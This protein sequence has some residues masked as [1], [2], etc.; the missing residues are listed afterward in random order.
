MIVIVVIVLGVVVYIGF[1]LY[2]KIFDHHT[3]KINK[4]DEKTKTLEEELKTLR[5]Q[6]RLKEEINERQAPIIIE[7]QNMELAEAIIEK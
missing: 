5:E 4:L 7:C 3:N 2:G 1:F 6:I